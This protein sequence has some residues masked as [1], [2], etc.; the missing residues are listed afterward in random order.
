MWHVAHLVRL[1][2]ATAAETTWRYLSLIRAFIC[3]GPAAANK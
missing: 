3:V 2:A 1:L